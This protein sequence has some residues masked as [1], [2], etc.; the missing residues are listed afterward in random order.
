MKLRQAFK[1][2]G[3]S[4]CNTWETEYLISSYRCIKAQ[5]DK[6]HTIIRRYLKN[7]RF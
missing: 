7:G 1:I 5:T 3:I 4:K 2:F 6:A